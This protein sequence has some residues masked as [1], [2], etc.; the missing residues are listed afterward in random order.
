MKFRLNFGFMTTGIAALYLIS[1]LAGPQLKK[2]AAQD[3]ARADAS[4]RPTPHMPDGH[5]DLTGTWYTDSG[6]RHNV[7]STKK[8]DGSIE[9]AYPTAQPG[10]AAPVRRMPPYK[11]E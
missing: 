4:P 10:S 9:L 6:H 8:S 3:S 5:P 1:T 11:P 2:A 7:I